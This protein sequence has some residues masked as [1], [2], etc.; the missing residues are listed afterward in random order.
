MNYIINELK[1]ALT[2]NGIKRD[3]LQYE[4]LENN[5]YFFTASQYNQNFFK[6][7]KE[8]KDQEKFFDIILNT[9]Y[10]WS[11]QIKAHKIVLC[12]G[13][14]YFNVLFASD[15]FK[16]NKECKEL[17]IEN[18]SIDHSILE[19]LID[20]LYTAQIYINENNVQTLLPAAKFLQIEEVVNA[21]CVFLHLNIDSNNCIGIEEFAMQYGCVDLMK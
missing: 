21:C 9:N 17:T 16:E 18:E 13:S 3:D 20:F 15:S 14:A 6:H 8:L 19:Q 12:S 5:T 2:D 10:S 11:R 1:D 4:K 7:L